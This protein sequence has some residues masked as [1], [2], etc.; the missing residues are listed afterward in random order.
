[1]CVFEAEIDLVYR[2][3]GLNPKTDGFENSRLNWENVHLIGDRAFK[4]QLFSE[5]CT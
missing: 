4:Y 2:N 1:M 5:Y 3:R